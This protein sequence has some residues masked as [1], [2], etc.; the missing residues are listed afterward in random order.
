METNE[1]TLTQATAKFTYCRFWDNSAA[2]FIDLDTAAIDYDQK[3]TAF[4]L[5]DQTTDLL[6]VGHATP[7]DFAYLGFRVG[8]AGDYV[9]SIWQYTNNLPATTIISASGITM[10]FRIAGNHATRFTADTNFIV[11]NSPLNNG[12][13]IVLSSVDVGANTDITV[14]NI[15]AS[16]TTPNAGDINTVLTAFTPIYDGTL[17]W[18]QSGYIT[19]AIPGDWGNTITIDGVATYWIR[20]KQNNGITTT[21]EAFHLMPNVLLNDPMVADPEWAASEARAF[22]DTAGDLQEGDLQNDDIRTLDIEC[23]LI[24]FG[25]G[26]NTGINLIF[27]WKNFRRRVWIDFG[28]QSA[29]PDFET[30]SYVRDCEGLLM[31]IPGRIM[32]PGIQDAGEYTLGFDIDTMN[33]L[34]SL[35][36]MTK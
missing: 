11:S 1:I 12:T 25:T 20:I 5:W 2:A 18:S 6:Y 24:T 22:T 30:D 13:Y 4:E 7:S 8:V 21:A 36:G 35:L 26:T 9:G 10:K 19:W 15:P 27:H 32:M 17:D 14:A 23:T 31:R 29:S 28:P 16:E 3:A 34:D 33:T